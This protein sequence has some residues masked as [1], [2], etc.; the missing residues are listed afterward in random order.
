M[1]VCMLESN[2]VESKPNPQQDRESVE[3][4]MYKK[5]RVGD[6]FKPVEQTIVVDP[7]VLASWNLKV[8]I[9][10]EE[11]V[12]EKITLKVYLEKRKPKINIH[13]ESCDNSMM[14]G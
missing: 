3:V 13:C 11:F 7:N 4:G 9:L 14:N 12:N 10:M 1:N 6:G 2:I 8:N 5:P